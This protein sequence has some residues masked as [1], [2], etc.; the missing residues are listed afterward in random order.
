[1]FM[2]VVRK[3]QTN[4]RLYEIEVCM[5]AKQRITVSAPMGRSKVGTGGCGISAMAGPAI[6]GTGPGCIRPV[7]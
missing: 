2:D 3:E 7:S 1:M 6:L 4:M 5:N